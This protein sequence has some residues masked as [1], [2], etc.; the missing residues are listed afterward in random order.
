MWTGLIYGQQ[1]RTCTAPCSNLS[2]SVLLSLTPC[3]SC[4]MKPRGRHPADSLEEWQVRILRQPGRHCD[5]N[6]LYLVVDRSGA[7]RWVLRLVVG[8]RRRD[9]GLGGTSLVSLAEAREKARS[10]RK[11][12]RRGGDPVAARATADAPFVG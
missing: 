7:S 5:G 6:G 12:A 3:E 10:L 9:I 2:S 8:G 1:T 11:I 4:Q